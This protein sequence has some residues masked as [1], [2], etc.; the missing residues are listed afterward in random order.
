MRKSLRLNEI[1]WAAHTLSLACAG[2]CD[3]LMYKE[4]S[5]SAYCNMVRRCSK[6]AFLGNCLPLDTVSISYSST[7]IRHTLSKCCWKTSHITYVWQRYTGCGRKRSCGGPLVFGKMSRNFCVG[8][9]AFPCPP[10]PQ[11]GTIWTP[12]H[13]LWGPISG[14]QDFL[15]QAVKKGEG[16]RSARQENSIRQKI[17]WALFNWAAFTSNQWKSTTLS[18]LLRSDCKRVCV[19]VWGGGGGGSYGCH[20]CAP[21]RHSVVVSSISDWVFLACAPSPFSFFHCLQQ[22]V[23]MYRKLDLIGDVRG[24]RWCHPEV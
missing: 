23:L 1:V 11:G 22:K 7:H 18:C 13:H 9:P 2:L 5:F 19:C 3:M 16:G 24:F 15:L 6:S 8:D 17:T 14:H 10:K 21:V 4:F 20:A 12:L